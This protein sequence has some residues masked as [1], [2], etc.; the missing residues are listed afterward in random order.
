[1]PHPTVTLINCFEVD[2]S[3]IEPAIA[4]WE[5]VHGILRAQPGYV[6]TALHRALA[7]SARFQLVNVARWESAE[8][9][10]TAIGR[11]SGGRPPEV[12]GL[13]ALPALYTVVRT[14]R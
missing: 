3:R 8:H 13:A 1:M 5:R 2:P 7:P 6:D 11:L 10:H 4:A 9:F 14:D 12:A